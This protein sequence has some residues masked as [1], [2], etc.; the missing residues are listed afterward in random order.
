MTRGIR[1]E[2]HDPSNGIQCERRDTALI[3][4]GFLHSQAPGGAATIE[5][6]LI[7]FRCPEHA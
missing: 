4:G 7:S 3:F 1:C 6:L 5:R 2:F